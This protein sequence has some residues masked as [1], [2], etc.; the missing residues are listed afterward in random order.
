MWHAS[1]NSN[2]KTAVLTPSTE[3]HIRLKDFYKGKAEPT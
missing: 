2:D 1:G 3:Q